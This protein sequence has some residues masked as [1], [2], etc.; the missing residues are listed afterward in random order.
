MNWDVICWAL[1]D[2]TMLR[3]TRGAFN[4]A[5]TLLL[6]GAHA[7]DLPG[8]IYVT[9]GGRSETRFRFSLIVSI[10]ES[11]VE[12]ENRIELE[13]APIEEVFNALAAVKDYLDTLG[14]VLA[15]LDT[16]QA[17]L[18]AAGMYLNSPLF[19]FDESYRILAITRD[20]TFQHD[21]EWEHMLTEG[22]LSPENA[23][24]MQLRG[25]LDLL[26]AAHEPV[27]YRSEIYPF[28]SV[29]VNIWLEDRFASRL[30]MLCVG[31][32]PT[33]VMAF[34]CGI[35]AAHL[36]RN[37][38][39][40]AQ[41]RVSGPLRGMLTD[42]LSGVQL[43]DALI[44]DRLRA[45]PGWSTG[46]LRVFALELRM[47]EDRQVAAYY[48][49]VLEELFPDGEVLA[50]EVENSLVLLAHAPDEEGFRRTEERLA[51]FLRRQNMVCGMSNSF[52]SLREA[53]GYY[54]QARTAL[55][56]GKE[57]PL[58]PYRG[59]MLEQ[60]MSYIPR[61]RAAW[62]VSPDVGRLAEADRTGGLELSATLRA[63]LE[64]DRSLTQTAQALFIHK[65]TLLYRLGRIR[66]LIRCDLD[67]PDERLLLR[68]SFRL[69][70]KE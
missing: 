28:P 35:V 36:R 37:L 27:I 55:R 6:M 12:S 51:A 21:A 20:V 54:D 48:A 19:Y 58:R 33:P 31:G 64:H 42:L 11:A 44:A 30:N 32:E 41:R 14:G 52:H 3:V 45:R 8:V 9:R 67:D 43:S 10:G 24:K 4:G 34:A 68:L 40:R 59:H 1:H 15:N 17:I 49:G 26:A 25:D 16:D 57:T 63:Y 62:L 60:I 53:R 7:P 13:D 69:M 61:E 5:S 66:E 47:R 50:L 39:A 65:N 22:Y 56:L 70:D 18:D 46:V 2:F 29:V 38:G 23:R